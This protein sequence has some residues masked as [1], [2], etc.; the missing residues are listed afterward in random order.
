MNELINCQMQKLHFSTE[1]SLGHNG[2]QL[3]LFTMSELLTDLSV[4]TSN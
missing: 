1:K 4:Q 3:G 2:L